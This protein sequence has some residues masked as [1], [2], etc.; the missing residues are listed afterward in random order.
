MYAQNFN[1]Q[2]VDY[3]ILHEF[4]F[5][6]HSVTETWNRVTSI[7]LIPSKNDLLNVFILYGDS[8]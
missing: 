7:K 8:L 1:R 2:T 5:R 6:R 4:R 3:I